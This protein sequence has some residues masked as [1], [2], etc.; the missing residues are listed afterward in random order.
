V[1]Q[2]NVLISPEVKDEFLMGIDYL[3]TCELTKPHIIGLRKAIEDASYQLYQELDLKE[4]ILPFQDVEDIK[5]VLIHESKPVFLFE[6]K[7][8]GDYVL[9]AS[10]VEIDKFINSEIK[11]L[12]ENELRQIEA[13]GID[14]LTFTNMIEHSI[15]LIP[16]T[17]PKRQKRRPVPPHYVSA[18]KKQIIGMEDAGLIEAST[19]PWSSPIHI[20][21]KEGTKKRITQDYK[22]LNV[23]T[24]KDAYPLPNIE[25]MLRSL[26]NARIFTKL[27]LTHGYW[28]IKVSKD[29]RKYTAFASEAGFHQFKVLPMGLT[30][31]CATFQ[32]LMDK[33]LKGLIGEICFVYLDDIISFSEDEENH[34]K[35]VKIVAGRLKEANLKVKLSKCE[36]AVKK[37]LI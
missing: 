3:E 8:D 13:K 10:P 22:K 12:I 4:N 34:L 31:A 30:N 25:N 33:L 28:Q 2:T 15:E 7:V 29:S 27:D 14:D 18:F 37:F 35:H 17:V 21:R 19:S 24:V 9:V 23:V 16:R 5:S 36:C 32:R 26:S 1:S 11:N 6:E 20:V